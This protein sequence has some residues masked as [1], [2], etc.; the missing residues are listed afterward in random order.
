M[1]KHEMENKF[2]GLKMKRSKSIKDTFRLTVQG[3]E[4][5][6]DYKT[7]VTSFE[8]YKEL[9]KYLSLISKIGKEITTIGDMDRDDYELTEEESELMYEICPYSEYGLHSLEV[10]EFVYFDENGDSFDIDFHVEFYL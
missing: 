6:G 7:E 3:D 5:D 4:N 10:E 2:N 1:T 8:S 9:E